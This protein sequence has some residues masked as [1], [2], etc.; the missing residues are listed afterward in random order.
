[1]KYSILGAGF[2]YALMVASYS[3]LYVNGGILGEEYLSRSFA[4]LKYTSEGYQLNV[5]SLVPPIVGF[6]LGLAYSQAK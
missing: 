6:L 5:Y 1:M 4:F 2:G 3:L